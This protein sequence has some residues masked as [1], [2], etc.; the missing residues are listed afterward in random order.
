VAAG[1][2]QE[3]QA[4][5]R[6][7]TIMRNAG[8]VVAAVLA[9]ATVLVI[10]L[11]VSGPLGL[12]IAANCLAVL[13]LLAIAARTPPGPRPQPG[14]FFTGALSWLTRGW[15]PRGGRRPPPVQAADFPAYL[16]IS[17]DLAWAPVSEWHYDHGVRPLL[18]RLL[19]ARLAERHRLD[20]A[21]DPRRARELVGDDI[22]PLVDPLRPVSLDSRA[23]GADVTALTRVVDRLEQL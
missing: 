4:P 8:V 14:T 11:G 17:S 23:P 3:A 5:D 16:K 22:W 10:A 21:A 7:W 9:C 6:L 19:R 13:G 1:A 2:G 20:P 15:L 18:I 12:V